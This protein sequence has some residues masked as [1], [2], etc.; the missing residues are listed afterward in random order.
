MFYTLVRNGCLKHLLEDIKMTGQ[1]SKSSSED[2]S[3]EV[4][5]RLLDT[6]E[7]L[8]AEHGF[9]GTS[10]RDIT[11]EAGCNVAAVNYHFGGKEKLYVDVFHRLMVMLREVRVE[12][13]NKLMSEK[14]DEVTLEEL[15]RVFSEV[16]IAPIMDKSGGRGLMK[17]WMREMIDHRL[18]GRM[19][20]EE[21][22]QPV[23]SS[24]LGAM[25]KIYPNLDRTKAIMSI[26]SVIAQLLHVIHAQ[27][28]FAGAE[29]DEVPLLDMKRAVEHIV[30]FSAAGIRCYAEG[31]K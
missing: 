30:K 22:V 6:A 14:G 2:Q 23:M 21:T 15:L 1:E 29:S 5:E 3:R 11:S 31:D 26:Q 20:I 24:L 7:K 13:I 9:N 27:D 19:F 12:G 10:V 16:F 25:L 17:L 18:P 8:F 4:K 28:I